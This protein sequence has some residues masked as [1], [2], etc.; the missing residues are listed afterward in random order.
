MLCICDLLGCYKLYCYIKIYGTLNYPIQLTFNQAP[1]RLSILEGA[2]YNESAASRGDPQDTESAVTVE[3]GGVGDTVVVGYTVNKQT[4]AG[5]TLLQD[6]LEQQMIGENDSYV[7]RHIASF[8]S[9]PTVCLPCSPVA[10]ACFGVKVPSVW[11]QKYKA[12]LMPTF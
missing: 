4:A 7:T 6:Q 5:D 10:L 8:H 9:S 12:L 11:L 1:D 2:G 3:G